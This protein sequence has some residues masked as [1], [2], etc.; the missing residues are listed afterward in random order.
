[1][2]LFGLLHK[3]FAQGS[4][5]HYVYAYKHEPVTM[6]PIL[7]FESD[8]LYFESRYNYEAAKTFSFYMGRTFSKDGKISYSISPMAGALVGTMTGGSLAANVE[9]AYKQFT[10]SSQ[11]QY[12]FSF[13]NKADAFLYSWNDLFYEMSDFLAV[14]ISAQQNMTVNSRSTVDKGLF[15]QG[16]FKNIE[17]PV[18]C[19]N[20]GSPNANFVFGI[21]FPL[22]LKKSGKVPTPVLPAFPIPQ[23][24]LSQVPG[25]MREPEVSQPAIRQVE[26]PDNRMYAVLL[27]PFKDKQTADAAVANLGA[28][29]SRQSISQSGAGYT[30]RV[31]G[32]RGSVAAHAYIDNNL[33]PNL[34]KQCL[35]VPYREV[36]VSGTNISKYKNEWK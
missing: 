7:S 19:F 29:V 5:Q 23:P 2:I 24:I 30:V 36:N 17:I 18:Y 22:S 25:A 21:S 13:K 27:G 1:M 6:S 35:L 10:L 34:K 9:I 12:T 33:S 3:V 31:M 16:T 28:D 26:Q 8:K 4:F 20:P 15:L 32:F 11:P 14:G